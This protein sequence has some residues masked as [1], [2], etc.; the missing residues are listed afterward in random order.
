M[1]TITETR[2]GEKGARAR[3]RRPSRRQIRDNLTG[4]LFFAPWMINLILLNAFPIGAAIYYSFTEYSVLQAPRWIGLG[5]YHE[6]FF[7]DELFWTAIY[8]T[9]YYCLFAVPLGLALSLFLAVLLNYRIRGI[10]F[11]RTTFFL[12]SIVPAVAASIVWAWILHPEYGLI[13]DLLARVGI[14]GPPWLTSEIWSKPAFILMSLWG[15]GPTTIIFLAGLQDIPAHLYEAA[16]IDGA[17]SFQRF[18]HVTVPMLTPTIFFNLVIGLIGAFQI[19]TQVYIISEGGPL[20]STLFY[21]YYLYRHGFQY[22]NMGYAS[23]L[24]LVLF[25]IILI[26]TLIVL[27]T[28]KRWVYY[29]GAELR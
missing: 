20:W 24:A 7:V 13:N 6:M 26:L 9:V 12:P 8:N 15:I 29:E 22:F 23:A 10:S 16:E 3:L 25:A 4:Y 17:N 14:P 18:R 21:V 19:F 27:V 2:P 28:S 1:T 11:F 5:N